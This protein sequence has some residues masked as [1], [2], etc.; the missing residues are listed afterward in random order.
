MMDCFNHSCPFRV[1]ETSNA[2]R[3][4]CIACQN[5][6]NSNFI[7]ASNRTFADNEEDRRGIETCIAALESELTVYAV[8]VVRCKD[9]IGQSTWYNDAEYD[10]AI[11]G[12]SGMYLKSKDDY[13]SYGL[14]KK[15]D[16]NGWIYK[17][18]STNNFNR[19][20]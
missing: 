6:S 9:C 1:N 12:L 13:C 10:C 2:N 5:R 8:E 20:N 3:C 19:I 17:K 4:D 7:I 11:C 16:D 14:R 15:G 18:G